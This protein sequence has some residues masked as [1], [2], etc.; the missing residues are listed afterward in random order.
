MNREKISE[1]LHVFFSIPR[2]E[3][4]Y[5]GECWS[6]EVPVF[7]F[8]FNDTDDDDVNERKNKTRVADELDPDDIVFEIVNETD[9]KRPVPV[10]SL[11]KPLSEGD[12]ITTLET[13]DIPPAKSNEETTTQP[14][15]TMEVPIEATKIATTTTISTS[16]SLDPDMKQNTLYSAGRDH[17]EDT[18]DVNADLRKKGL[19]RHKISSKTPKP[20]K[21]ETT[22]Y[23][24]SDHTSTMQGKKK[25]SVKK[26]KKDNSFNGRLGLLENAI[27]TIPKELLYDRQVPGFTSKPRSSTK[28]THSGNQS[29][30]VKSNHDLTSKK[31]S[32]HS[33]NGET[34]TNVKN[35]D[36]LR[37]ESDDDFTGQDLPKLFQI[38]NEYNK[39]WT[40]R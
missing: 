3:K 20:T 10:Q 35:D 37:L 8:S 15:S 7:Y 25:A 2:V 31:D 30:N 24:E 33:G 34:N 13:T 18:K 23:L 40:L 6:S 32:K 26:V 9:V 1:S 16:S 28:H 39:P 5:D 38:L 27:P 17:K 22:A 14:L 29:K 12:N 21:I 36:D 19:Y 4:V 11:D